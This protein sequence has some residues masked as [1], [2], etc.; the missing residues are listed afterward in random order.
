M[1]YLFLD[2]SYDITLGLLSSGLEWLEFEKFEG[3]KASRV[4]QLESY[5]FLSKHNV[6][7]KDLEGIISIAGP[8][9]YTGLRVSEGFGDLFQ[10]FNIPAYRFYSFE[11]PSFCGVREGQW[12]TKAYRGEYFLAEWSHGVLKQSNIPV[13]DL[14]LT[15]KDIK[16]LYIHSESSLDES[17]LKWIKESV[18]TQDLLKVQPH[19]IFSQVIAAKLNRDSFYFRAPEDEFKMNP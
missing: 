9:F 1:A 15:L 13:A 19:M 12:F 10:F 18:S 14:E 7:P 6:D 11:I 4:L 3:Q 5:N 2:S 8:G 16:K 17:S